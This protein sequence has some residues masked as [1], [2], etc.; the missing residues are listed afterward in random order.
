MSAFATET[1]LPSIQ[2]PAIK[3][4]IKSLCTADNW[5]NAWYLLRTWLYLVAVMGT[6]MYLFVRIDDGDHPW[7]WNVPVALVAIVLVGAGQHQLTGLAHEASHSTLFRNKKLNDL[8]SDW[9]CMFPMFSTTHHYRLQHIAHHQFTND[10]ERDPDVSQLKTSGHWLPFPMLKKEFLRTVLKQLWVPTLVRYI[11][12]RA[13]Y[14]AMGTDKNPYLRSTGKPTPK[15]AVR[16]AIFYLLGLVVGLG[17]L[18]AYAP[19]QALVAAPLVAGVAI[20][21]FYALLPDHY[22]KA[23]RVRSVYSPKRMTMM[24]MAYF[25][26]Y[27]S[28]IAWATRY[29]GRPV[30]EWMFVLWVVP[31]FTS[32]SFFMVLRQLVQ[33]GNADRGWMTNTR[34]FFVNPFI[35]FAVF[36]MGQDFHLPHHMYASVP[37]FKLKELHETLMETEEY[38]N[39]STV[40]EG[41]FFPPVQPPRNPTVLDVVGPDFAGRKDEV[42]VDHSV[43]DSVDVDGKEELLALGSSHSNAGR[44]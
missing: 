44:L 14:N 31:I 12:I 9:L 8:A 35:R 19:W 37:H 23:S 6:A 24:R 27:F 40:V 32:F 1:K 43:L 5:T 2:D 10:P 28:C 17:L 11:R 13:M 38:R 15:T 34:T 22:Y 4:K 3:A 30:Y 20:V 16:A 25:T 42:H 29:T 36:P 21:T 26:L 41:Y 39:E 7:W 18:T 33:H